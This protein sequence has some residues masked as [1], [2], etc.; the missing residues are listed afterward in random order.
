MNVCAMAHDDAQPMVTPTNWTL[1]SSSTLVQQDSALI[2][3]SRSSGTA[4]GATT[5]NYDGNVID[6]NLKGNGINI[7]YQIKPIP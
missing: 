1:R 5:V 7:T 6:G 4:L 2:I 3:F